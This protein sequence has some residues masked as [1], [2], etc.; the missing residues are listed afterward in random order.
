MSSLSENTRYLKTQ[1]LKPSLSRKPQKSF[2]QISLKRMTFYRS[3]KPFNI[4]NSKTLS[5]MRRL[6]AC[7][8]ITKI[9]RNRGNRQKTIISNNIN[10]INSISKE[11]INNNESVVIQKRKKILMTTTDENER[12]DDEKNPT[13]KLQDKE[14]SKNSIR[15]SPKLRYKFKL[16]SNFLLT[17]KYRTPYF[18]WTKGTSSN[19][20]FLQVLS[21]I[22][23]LHLDSILQ[24]RFNL[25]IPLKVSLLPLCRSHKKSDHSILEFN[26]WL[27]LIQLLLTKQ[28]NTHRVHILHSRAKFI[29]DITSN[30]QKERFMTNLLNICI[31]LIRCPLLNLQSPAILNNMGNH[32]LKN[33]V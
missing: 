21:L 16:F 10:N 4:P 27:L 11:K 5:S 6:W 29:K 33:Q 23:N 8:K 32:K 13:K 19:S 24:Y 15:K 9:Q 12:E 25:T 20:T 22:S 17:S 18:N 3:C 14:I 28:L 30:N 7:C 1:T 2:I 31:Q 26:K